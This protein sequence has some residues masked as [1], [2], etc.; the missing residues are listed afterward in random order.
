[1]ELEKEP[2]WSV[3]RDAPSIPLLPLVRA[4]RGVRLL[5]VHGTDEDDSLCDAL[6]PAEAIDMPMEGGHHFGRRYREIAEAIL[7]AAGQ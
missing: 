6:A 4:A 2:W 3:G 5:C 7:R 1:M